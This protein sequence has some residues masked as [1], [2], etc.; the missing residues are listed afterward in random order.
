MSPRRADLEYLRI[1]KLAADNLESDVELA[2]QLVLESD[3]TWDHQ[4]IAAL[5]EPT[6]PP[7]PDV[8]QPVPELSQYDQ[9]LVWEVVSD[10]A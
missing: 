3:E 2:L 10:P 7:A 9:L 4:T 5:V 6:I 8:E 1:L